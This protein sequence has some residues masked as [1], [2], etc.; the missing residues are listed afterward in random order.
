MTENWLASVPERVGA[1]KEMAAVPGLV[2][3]MLLLR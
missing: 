2:T 3:A 1:D